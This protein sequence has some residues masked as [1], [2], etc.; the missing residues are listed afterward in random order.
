VRHHRSAVTV[1]GSQFAWFVNVTPQANVRALRKSAGLVALLTDM[2]QQGHSSASAL[3]ADRGPDKL[4]AL[5]GSLAK[6]T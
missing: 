5:P 6:R 2:E 4:K 1:P 3:P